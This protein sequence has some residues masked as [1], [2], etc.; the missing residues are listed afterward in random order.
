[1]SDRYVTNYLACAGG[2]ATH[3]NLGPGGMGQSNGLFRSPIQSACRG[4]RPVWPRRE[5][6]TSQTL[7]VSESSFIVN[8]EEGCWI[9]DRFYLYHP[10]A[11][12]GDGSDFSEALGSTF[13]PSICKARTSSS[14]S[15][16]MQLPFG[17]GERRFRGRI[18][19]LLCRFR[20]TGHLAALGS[21]R[22]REISTLRLR[23]HPCPSTPPRHIS[24]GDFTGRHSLSGDFYR[25]PTSLPDPTPCVPPL[26]RPQFRVSLRRDLIQCPLAFRP[27]RP[28]P[29][30]YLVATYER[31]KH[32]DRSVGGCVCSCWWPA[33]RG[34]YVRRTGRSTS[35]TA[36]T[37]EMHRR[38]QIADN[39]GLQAAIP[40]TDA[41][42]TSPAIVGRTHLCARWFR[43]PVLRGRRDAGDRVAV[44]QSRWGA[45]LQQ[46]FVT[47]GCRKASY[48]SG[49][50]P[51]STFV[52]D[53]RDGH[54]VR[55]IECGEPVFSCP[56]VGRG[57]CLLRDLGIACIRAVTPEGEIRWTWD[58][59]REVLKF[60]GDRWSGQDW[61][62]YKKERVTWRE[63]FLCSREMAVHGKTLVMPAGGSI[64]WLAD[65]GDQAQML[66]GFAP[67][68]S[69]S[70]L[71][72]S[73]D[74]QG[75]VYR[76]WFRRDN[77]GRV[78]VLRIVD[79]KVEAGFVAGTETDYQSDPSM[80]FSSVSIRG[81]AVYRC[82]PEVDMGLCRH[83]DGQTIPLGDY[84]SIAPP[85]L[86][87]DRVL[88]ACLDGRLAI[89]PLGSG[90]IT[91]PCSRLPSGDRSRH[92][93]PWPMA[94]SCLEAKTATCTSL[95][96]TVM[97]RCP[98]S[99]WISRGVRSPL[100]SRFADEQFNWST[101]FG[102]PGQYESNAYRNSRRHSPC[103]GFD[104]V[105]GPSST[106]PPLAAGA[107][108]RTRP[109]GR[110]WRWSR[111]RDGCCGASITRACTFRLR[112]PLIIE[113]GCTCR[114]PDCTRVACVA[115]TR[116]RDD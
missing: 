98:P 12:S 69:P 81:H 10:N 85:I 56:V 61:L 32:D 16:P 35:T 99:H 55:E 82:R 11:D 8:E 114:R 19:A 63:Q 20:G 104:A 34:F 2:D 53:A 72:L 111:R 30:W 45:K 80:S 62:D 113:S 84:P 40:L 46:L 90:S 92:L 97:R 112:R 58:Y 75:T 48:I 65:R 101:H 83:E 54:V 91:V 89:V 38:A 95:G 107:C 25:F 24:R 49:R 110:S 26:D 41:V 17:R 6:G 42:F 29:Y 3:D 88:V 108:T 105:K 22:Q 60:P 14:A 77:G 13:Y 33:V 15:P 4:P 109:K 21:M 1:M 23:H 100:T 71:G 39:I 36:S 116:P 43:C 50:W 70:T 67:N 73:L 103:A 31:T 64:V 93:P 74:A 57:R 37:L 96:R 9:C 44:S 94:R 28:V 52:L 79:D 27:R 76:Q 78:E 115:W 47:G 87:G 106:C 68:E 7:M 102:E 86:A 66:G 51:A 59:V 5:D 18:D